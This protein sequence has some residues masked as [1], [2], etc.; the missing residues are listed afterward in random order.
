MKQHGMRQV[1]YDT[2]VGKITTNSKKVK[3]NSAVIDYNSPFVDFDD[4]FAR[5]RAVGRIFGLS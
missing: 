1:S 3:K 2:E 4:R 5:E